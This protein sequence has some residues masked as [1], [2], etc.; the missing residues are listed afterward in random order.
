MTLD[1]ALVLGVLQGATEFLPVSSSGHLALA[2]SLLPNWEGPRLLFDVVVHLGTLAAITLVL[3]G[4][5]WALARA[6]LSFLP[7]TP[8]RWYRHPC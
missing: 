7:A 8:G 5:M 1:Q 6:A 4:R 2:Q 3:R